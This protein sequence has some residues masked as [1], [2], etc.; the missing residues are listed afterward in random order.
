MNKGFSLLEVLIAIFIIGVLAAITVNNMSGARDRKIMEG[1]ADEIVA[2]LEEVKANSQIGKGGLNYGIKFNDDSYVLFSGLSYDSGDS[3]NVTISINSRMEL[4]NTISGSS[5]SVV[6]S[7]IKG[8]PNH[9]G[10]ITVSL[11]SDPSES[12]DIVIGELGDISVIK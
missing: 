1:T 7:K 3:N 10:T 6:F 12:M 8:E 11:I 5:D 2:K 9:T 4:S